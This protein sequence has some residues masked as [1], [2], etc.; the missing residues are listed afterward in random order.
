MLLKM[1]VEN[2]PE[3]IGGPYVGGDESISPRFREQHRHGVVD[4]ISG[5]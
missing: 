4:H 1:L 3:R 5:V 2:A